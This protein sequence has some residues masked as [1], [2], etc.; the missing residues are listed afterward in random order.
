MDSKTVGEIMTREVKTISPTATLREAA[1]TLALSGF[2]GAPVVDGDGCVIGVIT[3]SDLMNEAKKRTALP[4]I[5]AF[6][7]FL[8][9][10]DALRRIYHDGADL[11]V[12]EVMTKSVESVT[13]D[14]SLRE[15]TDLMTKKR[16][17]RIPVVDFEGKL[18]GL[19]TREDILRAL[20]DLP[21]VH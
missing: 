17:N 3:E 6:G 8:A 19:V 13:G 14:A 10:E 20:F 5:G 7:L 11:L 15:V 16:I 2:S 21:R 18:V 1:E 12:E 9:P 4:H